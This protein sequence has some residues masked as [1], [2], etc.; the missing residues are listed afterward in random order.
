MEKDG[1]AESVEY[2]VGVVFSPWDDAE[3]SE[4]TLLSKGDCIDQMV[5][6]L[7]EMLEDRIPDDFACTGLIGEK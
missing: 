1:T 3:G 2:L 4:S 5:E 6:N 7:R